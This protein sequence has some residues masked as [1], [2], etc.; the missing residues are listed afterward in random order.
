MKET[1]LS[2]VALIPARGG[3]KGV[4]GKNIK[5]L[6]GYPLIAFSIVAAKLAKTIDRVIV[7]TDSDEIAAISRQYGAE[8]PFIRP[9]KF[10]TDSSPDSDFVRHALEWFQQN[11]GMMPDLLV[12]LRPTTPLRDPKIIDEAVSSLIAMKDATSLRSAHPASES[13]FKWFRKDTQGYF[14]PLVDGISVVDANGA[15]Q[16]FETIYVP[17]GYVDVLRT[18]YVSTA[19]DIHG[20]KIQAFV[21]PVCCEVDTVDD[22]EYLEYE[23]RR[24][25][26]ELLANL[27]KTNQ[28]VLRGE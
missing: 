4:P 14:R 10:A 21:S 23:F 7:S 8:V 17:D 19:P 27:M 24:T 6:G 16:K 13:P 26:S 15:R 2:T 9:A 20:Q 5:L 11:E 25:P 12:H 28:A 1:K 18:S 22:F 3:S